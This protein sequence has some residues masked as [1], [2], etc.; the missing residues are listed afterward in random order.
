AMEFMGECFPQG[1]PVE[2]CETLLPRHVGTKPSAL[3]ESPFY[4][5]ASSEHY[6]T[7]DGDPNEQGILV[8]I[9]GAPFKGFFVAA[10]DTQMGERIG[11]WTKLRGTTPLPCSAIT[12]KDSKSKKLVQL[13]WIPPPY[14]KGLVTFA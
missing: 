14:S 13:L 8:E 11:N 10:I 3:D 9:G 12:H 1:A 5:A 4:F 7:I 2:S 6:N